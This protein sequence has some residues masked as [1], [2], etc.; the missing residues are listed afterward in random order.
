MAAK[1][2]LK[3][4]PNSNGGQ[5]VAG[6]NLQMTPPNI[7]LKMPEIKIPDIKSDV[8]VDMAPVAR[9]F[10]EALQVITSQLASQQQAIL[11]ILQQLAAKDV[12]VSV[13]APN[14]TVAAAKRPRSYY[15]EFMKEDGETTGMRISAE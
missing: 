7:H 13:A 12:K 10:A 4:K 6:L 11:A 3:T 14:V 15:V 2:R 9:A 1:D 5:S 8:T